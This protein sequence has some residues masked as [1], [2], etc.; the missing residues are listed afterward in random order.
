[1]AIKGK[2]ARA[3]YILKAAYEMARSGEYRDYTAIEIA[4]RGD[5]FAEARQL[6]DDRFRRTELNDICTEARQERDRDK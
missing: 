1:M 4:L 5:G 6:L 2:K 3:K